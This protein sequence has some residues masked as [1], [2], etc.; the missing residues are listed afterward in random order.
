MLTTCLSCRR[1]HTPQDSDLNGVVDVRYTGGAR[2]LLLIEVGTGRWRI[3]IP[4][5]VSGEQQGGGRAVWCESGR[6]FDDSTGL[7]YRAVA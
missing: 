3:K 4:V 5:M 6:R 2:M 1:P 7:Q